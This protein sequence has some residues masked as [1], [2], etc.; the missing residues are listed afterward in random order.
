MQRLV[1]QL[2]TRWR[3]RVIR[4][5]GTP[6]AINRDEP[7]A[8]AIQRIGGCLLGLFSVI[9]FEQA[10]RPLHRVIRSPYFVPRHQ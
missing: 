6:I 5:D 9:R 7:E 4:P 8:F 1:R 3:V 2:V 10:E